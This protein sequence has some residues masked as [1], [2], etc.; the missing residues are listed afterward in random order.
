M[1]LTHRRRGERRTLEL[2]ED[3]VRAGA[4]LRLNG[5]GDQGIGR[6]RDLVAQQLEFREILG[7]KQRL[8]HARELRHLH[9]GAFE[10]GRKLAIAAGVTLMDARALRRRVWSAEHSMPHEHPAV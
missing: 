1:H 8:L 5:G 6:W 9:R 2:R 7:R 4:E 3:L 10:R